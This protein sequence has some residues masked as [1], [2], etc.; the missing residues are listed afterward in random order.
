MTTAESNRLDE[1]DFLKAAAIVA[2][3]FTHSGIFIFNPRFTAWDLWLTTNWV[4]FHVPSFLMVSGFLYCRTEPVGL[5]QVGRRLA[6]IVVPYAIATVA[7]QASGV[8][9]VTG[10][11]SA[12][13]QLA[14]G[15]AVGFYYFVPVLA[16]CVLCIGPLSRAPWTLILALWLLLAGYMV[17]TGASPK[18]KLSHDAFWSQ[19]NPIESFYLGHFLTGWLAATH[20]ERLGA[21]VRRWRLALLGLCTVGL[22]WWFTG[23][24]TFPHKWVPAFGVVYTWSAAGFIL[25]ATWGVRAPGFVRWLSDATY[26]IYLYHGTPILRTQKYVIDWAPPARILFRA[27]LALGFGCGLTAA[28]RRLLGPTRSRRYLGS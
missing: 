3:V 14:T 4:W 2:V 7:M 9:T 16:C 28:A 8:G 12:L 13:F 5:S 25:L 6:R 11:G 22:V 18:L 17:A 24:A 20:R 10:L 15:S 27:A 19:R 1:I 26:T 23:V 21:F